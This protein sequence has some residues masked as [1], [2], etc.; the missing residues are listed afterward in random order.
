MPLSG[1]L[2]KRLIETGR[3]TTGLPP[4]YKGKP[5]EGASQNKLDQAIIKRR[6]EKNRA[7]TGV[8]KSNKQKAIDV[9][10]HVSGSPV[11]RGLGR[12]ARIG[13]GAGLA[14]GGGYPASQAIL[15]KGDKEWMRKVGSKFRKKK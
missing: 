11:A 1:V 15:T 3:L 2:R 5:L 9:V 10:S 4:T 8:T 6:I 14:V 12:A 13:L 7:K